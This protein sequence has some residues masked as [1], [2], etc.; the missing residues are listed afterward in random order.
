MPTPEQLRDS[1]QIVLPAETLAGLRAE[2]E[3][4]FAVSVVPAGASTCRIVGSPVA[5]KE[6]G[7]FL[8]RHGVSV[9]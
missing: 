2:L 4:E 6:V 8:A 5:I 7:R 9:P 1:T 3:A